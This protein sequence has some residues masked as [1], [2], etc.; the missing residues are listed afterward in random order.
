MKN[1]K[2]LIG[3]GL[4][5]QEAEAY[6]ALLRLGESNAGN[7]A[8]EM[9]VKRTSVYN[10]LQSLTAQGFAE[11]Y[12]NKKKLCYLPAKPEKLASRFEKKL[13]TF[14][15]IIPLLESVEKKE[16][17]SFGLRLIDTTEELKH[18]Y[19]DV[20]SEY[21]GK[22]YRII[23][24]A[25]AWEGI[26]EDFFI[27]FRKDRAV[28]NIKTKLL[29]S[30]DSK[31]INP[32]SSSLLREFR[33]LPEKYTFESTLDIFEDKILIV[34]PKMQSLAIVIAVPVVVDIFQSVFDMLWEADQT[35]N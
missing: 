14:R 15:S 1:K 29:L 30:A 11:S 19:N 2:I 18:F 8:K 10:I 22:E 33:Y 27:Q 26:D 16:A 17:R 35:K 13:E 7:L 23:G 20:L 6:L 5:D 9:G 12:I 32:T 28:R 4:S 24:S 34:N 25:S 3:L 21:R 31:T